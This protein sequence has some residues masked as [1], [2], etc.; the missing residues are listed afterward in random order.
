MKSKVILLSGLV[1]ILATSFFAL[2]GQ[3]SVSQDKQKDQS[4]K[5]EIQ[6]SEEEWKKRLTPE[7]YHILREQGTERAFTGKLNKFYEKG[8]YYSAASLQP[9]FSSE[10][11][12]N[13][14][15]GWPSFWKPIDDDAIKLVKDTTF[16]MVRWEVVDSK[17][18]SH[19]G[20]VF[21]DGPEPTGK[22][23]C[24]NSAAL[25]FVP[26]GEEPPKFKKPEN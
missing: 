17:S 21:D 23:Y 1:V 19:L 16:G 5:Y 4:E 10:T 14:Y 20:H 12:Y 22:R 25:I 8:T 9:V 11:K 6:L 3:E 24:L 7:Q 18:G 2:K 15:S 13:S 26:E